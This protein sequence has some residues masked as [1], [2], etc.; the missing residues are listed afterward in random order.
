[1][2][3]PY[4]VLC[5]CGRAATY[6]IAARWSDGLTGELKTYALCCS[7]CLGDS[8]RRSCAKHAHCR[9]AKGETLQPPEIFELCRGARDSHLV[10]R[11]DLEESAR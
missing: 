10:R 4:S 11:V 6:K 3:P 9:L 1:M 8:F 2:M 5:N 7:E